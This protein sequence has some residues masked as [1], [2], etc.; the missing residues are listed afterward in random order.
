MWNDSG[1]LS[2]AL[3]VLVALPL[4]YWV[5]KRSKSVLPFPPGPKP[6]PLIGNLLDVP[7]SIAPWEWL[8]EMAKQHGQ[9]LQS[10]GLYQSKR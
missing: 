6:Y 10:R 2:L 1:Y 4:W 5:K 8:K 7:L 3:A 9:S